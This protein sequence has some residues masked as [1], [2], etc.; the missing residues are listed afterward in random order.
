MPDLTLPVSK[1]EYDEADSKFITFPP[2]AAVG[3]VQFRNVEL[4]MVDWDTPGRSIK[5]PVTVIEEGADEGK[6][7]KISA[8]VK[9]DGVW[10]LK[11]ILKTF[12]IEV[13]YVNGKPVFNTDELTGKQCVGAWTL[14]EGHKGGDPTADKVKYP[15]LTALVLAKPETETLL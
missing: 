4:G 6:K 9:A 11:E 5:F 1:K 3:D 10:K 2:N 12:G 13:K 7:D 14:Q 15:K 8:G